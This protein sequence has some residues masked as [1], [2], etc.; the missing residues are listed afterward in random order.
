MKILN[1]IDFFYN[2]HQLIFLPKGY[3]YLHL[4]ILWLMIHLMTFDFYRKL[5]QINLFR[6]LN[7]IQYERRRHVSVS[8]YYYYGAKL[9]GHEATTERPTI[10]RR[11]SVVRSKEEEIRE[12]EA[13]RNCLSLL[14]RDYKNRLFVC[15]Y[16]HTPC[17]SY[18]LSNSQSA[19]ADQRPHMKI[20]C[21]WI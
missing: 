4:F 9:Y 13:Q 19:A 8:E 2:S 14:L 12:D 6:Y 7:N 15:K 11:Q 3:C 10:W 16:I 1:M 5:Q 18:H 21:I 20:Y 17:P